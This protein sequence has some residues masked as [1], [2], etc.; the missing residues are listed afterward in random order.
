MRTA[1]YCREKSISVFR[2]RLP[3][4]GGNRYYTTAPLGLASSDWPRAEDLPDVLSLSPCPFSYAG[5]GRLEAFAGFA[6]PAPAQSLSARAGPQRMPP[7]RHIGS[8]PLILSFPTD[9]SCHV[10]PL[11]DSALVVALSQSIHSLDGNALDLGGT[12]PA[13]GLAALVSAFDAEHV[14]PPAIRERPGCYAARPAAHFPPSM[15]NPPDQATSPGRGRLCPRVM[16]KSYLAGNREPRLGSQLVH[17]RN[18]LAVE[19][20]PRRPRRPVAL[21]HR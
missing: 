21:W 20:D 12:G 14:V 7:V 6:A 18:R 10:S 5:S 11:C 2:N 3:S 4:N 19:C 9:L 8:A 17:E 16:Y 13:R 1:I 15:A